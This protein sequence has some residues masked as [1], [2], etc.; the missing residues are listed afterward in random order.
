[1]GINKSNI[2]A[3]ATKGILGGIP[4]FGPLISEIVFAI[5]PDR[6]I[7]R[8][9][10][11]LKYLVSKIP[12]ID[13]PQVEQRIKSPES[14]DLLEDGFIQASRALSEERKDYIASLIKN[15]LTNNELKHIEYKKLMSLLSELN[16]L[17]ILIL[18]S[19]RIS[20]E[21]DEFWSKHRDSITLSPLTLDALQEDKDK[22]AFLEA[23]QLHLINIGLLKPYYSQPRKGTLPEFDHKTGMMEASG[24]SITYLGEL[25]LRSIDQLE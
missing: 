1:M 6:R 2:A 21:R 15:S 11:V 17:E 8:I 24:Y 9:E 25:L 14:V 5:I 12:E 10:T 3:I 13:R 20:S 19:N 22:Y 23:Y 16:D 18:K 4:Y 7:Q